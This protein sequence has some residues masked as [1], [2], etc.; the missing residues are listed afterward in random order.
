MIGYNA[1]KGDG[2]MLTDKAGMDKI[3]SEYIEKIK[4]ILADDFERAVVYGSY[5][6]GEY[7]RESD[8]DIAIFTSRK[9]EEFYLLINQIA[10]I[11]FE[12]GV[13]YDIIFSPVFQNTADFQR[14]LKVVPYFQNIQREG[15]VIGA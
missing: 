13:Q 2:V 9:A 3:I 1:I 11:T 7:N 15:I 10:E 12:Y 6:R 8:V 14:M 4:E 5:A